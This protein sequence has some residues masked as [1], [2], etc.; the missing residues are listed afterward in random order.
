MFGGRKPQQAIFTL[1]L[2][3]FSI[4]DASENYGWVNKAE[5]IPMSLKYLTRILRTMGTKKYPGVLRYIR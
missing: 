5:W 4:L 1:L 2:Q 3:E